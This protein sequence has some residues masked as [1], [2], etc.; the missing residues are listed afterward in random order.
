M[1]V[2][3]SGQVRGRKGVPGAAGPGERR[4]C[5]AP[6][7]LRAAAPWTSASVPGGG[8]SLRGLEETLAL[9]PAHR[10]SLSDL[11]RVSPPAGW[12][13]GC[14]WRAVAA[15][16]FEYSLGEVLDR[17]G[18][19]DWK[20]SA[21][22]LGGGLHG[23]IFRAETGLDGRSRGS[24]YGRPRQGLGAGTVGS[25]P[26][27]PVTRGQPV[28]GGSDTGPAAVQGREGG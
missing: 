23:G 22:G 24:E 9:D 20:E 2:R 7:R 4:L 28:G 16:S 6:Y 8:S 27:V 14:F 18:G 3:N 21:A 1:R 19:A 13:R 12:T 10:R 11:R 15:P 5:A 17:F 26:H 25:A